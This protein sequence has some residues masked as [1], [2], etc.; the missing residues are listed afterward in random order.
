MNTCRTGHTPVGW[1]KSTSSAGLAETC[2]MGR[3][4]DPELRKL[5]EGAQFG[6][7][8]ANKNKRKKAKVIVVP[9]GTNRKVLIAAYEGNLSHFK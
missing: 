2:H 5:E 1:P 3:R 6:S 9:R 7:V 8:Q 4:F